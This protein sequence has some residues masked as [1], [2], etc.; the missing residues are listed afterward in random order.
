MTISLRNV[1]ILSFYPY[2]LFPFSDIARYKFR[3]FYNPIFSRNGYY[4]ML[5]I[6]KKPCILFAVYCTLYDS[7]PEIKPVRGRQFTAKKLVD[8]CERCMQALFPLSKFI[9]MDLF[10]PYFSSVSDAGAVAVSVTLKGSVSQD[11]LA[12]RVL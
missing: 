7:S 6:Q 11:P 8:Y 2:Q 10:I 5:R 9:R 1:N 3:L 4:C 12:H